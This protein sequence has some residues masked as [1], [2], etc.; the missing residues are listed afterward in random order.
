MAR[1]LGLL[2]LAAVAAHAAGQDDNNPADEPA[3]RDPHDVPAEGKGDSGAEEIVGLLGEV[4]PIALHTYVDTAQPQFDGLKDWQYRVAFYTKEGPSSTHKLR[5][6][7]V[8]YVDGKRVTCDLPVVRVPTDTKMDTTEVEPEKLLDPLRRTCEKRMERLWTYELCYFGHIRQYLEAAVQKTINIKHDYYLGRYP[9]AQPAQDN[10]QPEMP[11]LLYEGKSH[12]YYAQ[13]YTDGTTCDLTGKPREAEVRFF[14]RRGG[15]KIVE[16]EEIATCSYQVS[17]GTDLLCSD[18][19]FSSPPAVV[20]PVVC[21]A[22][23]REDTEALAL[24]QADMWQFTSEH[25]GDWGRPKDTSGKASKPKKKRKEKEGP[26]MGGREGIESILLSLGQGG[27]GVQVVQVDMHGNVRRVDDMHGNV[28]RVDDMHVPQDH[29]VLERPIAH[30]YANSNKP[31][32]AAKGKCFK[33]VDSQWRFE[34]CLDD[35]V[36]QAPHT[37]SNSIVLGEWHPSGHKQWLDSLNAMQRANL[38][39]DTSVTLWYSG[40]DFCEAIRDH[41]AVSVTLE[42]ALAGSKEAVALSFQ[43]DSTCRYSLRIR[44]RTLCALLPKYKEHWA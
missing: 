14:C 31:R 34:V 11:K 12:A 21:Q 6:T 27:E 5:D 15:T 8:A 20:S 36:A 19:R 40:G 17:V 22:D 4:P 13:K 24:K 16:V 44:S 1:R 43:E 37:G 39:T 41:R 18:P 23:T 2:L 30:Y 35:F 25:F 7:M 38:N 28:R 3:G 26:V 10:K 29:Q 32:G 42:C 33:G 9:A